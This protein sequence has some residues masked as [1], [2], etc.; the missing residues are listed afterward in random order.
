L[1]DRASLPVE[2][3]LYSPLGRSAEQR[4][5]AGMKQRGV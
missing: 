3:M 5:T 2:G 1:G 4:S